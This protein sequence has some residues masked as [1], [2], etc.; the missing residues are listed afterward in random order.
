MTPAARPSALGTAPP[1]GPFIKR[2]L[3]GSLVHL[4]GSAGAGLEPTL[5][6]ACTRAIEGLWP[7]RRALR[8][9]LRRP[10]LLH[11]LDCNLGEGSPRLTLLD[12]ATLG[13]HLAASKAARA[14]LDQAG[15]DWRDLEQAAHL[16]GAAR[17][18][19]PP[20]PGLFAQA[21]RNTIEHA[22]DDDGLRLALMEL[23][24]AIV[25]P[26]YVALCTGLLRGGAALALESPPQGFAP[27]PHRTVPAPTAAGGPSPLAG[28]LPG[29]WFRMVLHQQWTDAQ[30]TWCSHNGRFYMFSSPLG[31]RAHSLSRP[32]LEGLIQRGHFARLRAA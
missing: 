23:A 17:T 11:K 2:L 16:E 5:R 1:L 28:A 4:H 7:R 8:R 3:Q 30:L 6:Q 27:P 26:E 12:H 13:L 14:L 31:N 29:Q 18:P 25:V 32:A 20:T 15:A 22:T 10:P 21:V 19:W 9:L 24:I